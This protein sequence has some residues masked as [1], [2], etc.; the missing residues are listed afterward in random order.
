MNAHQVDLT[1]HLSDFVEEQVATGRYHDVGEVIREAL[2]RY[3]Q[4]VAAEQAYIGLIR[5]IASEGRAAIARGDFAF[6]DG[7]D[8][9]QALFDRITGRTQPTSS[10]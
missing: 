7:E 8:A 10:P 5:S 1:D 6:I 2:R 4:E 9:S 3:E